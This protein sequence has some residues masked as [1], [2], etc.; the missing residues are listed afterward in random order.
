MENHG[1]NNIVG[2]L[3]SRAI[4]YVAPG[5]LKLEGKKAKK[6]MYTVN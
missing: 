1:L 4:D 3:V 6:Q 5:W 2:S